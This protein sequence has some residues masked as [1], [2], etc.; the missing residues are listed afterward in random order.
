MV[1]LRKMIFFF[2]MEREVV[3]LD[4]Y[5]SFSVNKKLFS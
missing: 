1:I 5:L 4:L 3:S 2:P